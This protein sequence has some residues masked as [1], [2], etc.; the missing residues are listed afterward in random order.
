MLTSFVQYYE[1]KHLQP[2]RF[3]QARAATDGHSFEKQ[4]QAATDGHSFEKRRH[5]W[6]DVTGGLNLE[7]RLVFILN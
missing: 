3:K 5:F 4:A 7:H 1:L 6:N 2:S